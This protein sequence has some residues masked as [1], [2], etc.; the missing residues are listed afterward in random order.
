MRPPPTP[1]DLE[2]AMDSSETLFSPSLS[3]SLSIYISPRLAFSCCHSQHAHV[4]VRAAVLC[5]DGLQ[6]VSFVNVL[7]IRK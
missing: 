6:S 1:S 3:P 2:L 7:R 5:T 4:L